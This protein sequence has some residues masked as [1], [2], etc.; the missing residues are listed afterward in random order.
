MNWQY[1]QYIIGQLTTQAGSQL[2][3]R[4]TNEGEFLLR[5]IYV[6]PPHSMGQKD[7]GMR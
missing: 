6:Q 5:S 1:I 2:L 3:Q 7:G 4:S